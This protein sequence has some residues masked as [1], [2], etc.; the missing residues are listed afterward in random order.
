MGREGGRSACSQASG[1]LALSS[2]LFFLSGISATKKQ[3]NND[4][5]HQGEHASHSEQLRPPISHFIRGRHGH[6][7]SPSQVGTA[8]PSQPCTNTDPANL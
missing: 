7:L 5:N 2:S 6:D 4:S 3:E 8:E 1:L